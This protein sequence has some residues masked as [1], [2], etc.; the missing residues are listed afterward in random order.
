MLHDLRF[1]AVQVGLDDAPIGEI[2]EARAAYEKACEI[3]VADGE[4]AEA[5]DAAELLVGLDASQAAGSDGSTS[6]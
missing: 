6:E 5:T 4:D 1:H 3:E 2:G